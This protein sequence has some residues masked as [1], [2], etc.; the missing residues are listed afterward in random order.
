MS[1]ITKYFNEKYIKKIDEAERDLQDL[2][3]I[4][5]TNTIFKQLNKKA[6]MNFH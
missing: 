1:D 2:P 3:N 5:K 6:S 4:E